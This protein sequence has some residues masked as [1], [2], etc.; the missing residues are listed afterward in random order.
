M[1]SLLVA[2]LV[3]CAF[4]TPAFADEDHVKADKLFEEAQQLKQ[5]G[6]GK[7]ACDRYAEALTYNKNAVGTLLN[8]A[9]CNEDAG[10]IATAVNLYNQARDL[11]REHNLNE[12]RA[13]AEDRLSKI[14]DRVPRLA[15]AFEERVDG[16]KLVIDDE[17]FPTSADATNELRLD[18]GSRHVV[19]TAPG[20]LPYDIHVVLT[21]GKQQAIAIPKLAHPV[22]VNKARRT[23]GKILT[24]S[25]G[26]LLVTGL[27]LGYIADKDYEREFEVGNCMKG[28]MG[29]LCNAEGYQRTGEARQLGTVGTVVGIAGVAALGV[30]VF[31]WFTAPP[32]TERVAFVPSVT[33]DSAGIAAVGRF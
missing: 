28:A 23:V 17:V 19:V 31:L 10:K 6:K 32:E 21:E 1:R 3:V 11:A 4:G 13:A 5:A 29:S 22:T 26:A 8:V 20:R 25:G 33:N 15:I 24:A 12:H 30:G 2:A 9:K 16:M 27:V 7:E 14:G 18:P